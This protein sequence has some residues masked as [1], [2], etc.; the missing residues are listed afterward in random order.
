MDVTIEQSC[1]SCGASIV[2]SEDDRLIQCAY[3]DVHNY[4]TGSVGSRYVLPA[5][6]PDHLEDKQLIFAPY[7]RFKG[8]IFYVQDKEVRHKIVDTTRLGL[9][10]KHLPV[11]LGLRPQAMKIKPVG[12]STSG[13]FILQSIPTK[14]VFAHAAMVLDLFKEKNKKKPI[15]VRSSGKPLAASINHVI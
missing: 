6:L 13:S 9:D 3:C 15:I 2:L 12:S 5:K 10:N 7:L 4:K 1:P 8:S 11:S 14:T